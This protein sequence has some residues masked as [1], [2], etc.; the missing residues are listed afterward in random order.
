M[1]LNLRRGYRALSLPLLFI[2]VLFGLVASPARAQ[3]SEPPPATPPALDTMLSGT[4]DL[5]WADSWQNGAL[6]AQEPSLLLIDG[7]GAER[8]ITLAPDAAAAWGGANTLVGRDVTLRASAATAPA[9]MQTGTGP[10]YDIVAVGAATA[11]APATGVD[12]ERWLVLLCRPPE[13]TSPLPDTQAHYGDL[14]SSVA[15]GMGDF[16]R[17][18]LL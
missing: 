5:L 14:L 10:L 18:P 1:K 6:I 7:Q 11:S 15:P 3:D 16:W 4:L 12:A 9:S 17:E 2:L 13:Y 8:H